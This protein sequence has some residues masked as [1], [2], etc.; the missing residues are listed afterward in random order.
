MR[1]QI[2]S[3]NPVNN[4]L[5]SLASKLVLSEKEKA[6]ISTSII[7]LSRRLNLYFEGGELHTHF[8]IGSY[9]RGAFDIIRPPSINIDLSTV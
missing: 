8:Q 3:V 2:M 5:K 6:S 7:T 4:H 1:R 9:I